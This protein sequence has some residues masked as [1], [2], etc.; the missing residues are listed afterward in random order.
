MN[1]AVTLEQLA[2]LCRT[3]SESLRTPDVEISGSPAL[4]A[5][6][7]G[8]GWLIGSMVEMMPDTVGIGELQL[9]MPTLARISQGER[10]VALI[11]P[12]L[13]PFPPALSQ[14]GMRL[15]HLLVIRAEKPAD[16]LWA[17]EQ[18][19]RCKSFGAV[20]SWPTTIKDREVRRLQLA[21]EA[22]RSIG[23]LYRPI[24]AALEASPA[25]TRL[26]LL[27]SQDGS[28]RVEILKCRGGRAGVTVNCTRL[29][30]GIGLPNGPSSGPST[31]PST[32]THSAVLAACS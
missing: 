2:R 4:D 11:S 16:A 27:S 25:A 18:T 29:R 7:P 13:I 26:R 23:F 10:Y 20:V 32:A 8:G 31:G 15:D 12:P 28:L 21:A 30:D 22:G 9:L 17:C 6:L 3:G 5:A 1:R 14:Q 19:L 24:D